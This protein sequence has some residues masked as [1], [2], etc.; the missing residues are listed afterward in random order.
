[1]LHISPAAVQVPFVLRRLHKSEAL[2]GSGGGNHGLLGE[3]S[4][5]RLSTESINDCTNEI[6][7]YGRK[8]RLSLSLSESA[9]VEGGSLPKASY[10]HRIRSGHQPQEPMDDES[11]FILAVR[12]PLEFSP[13]QQSIRMGL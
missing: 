12:E 1:M 8:L 4:F 7:K 5:Q 2:G 13:L 9:V 11:E 10:R 3:R 6:A